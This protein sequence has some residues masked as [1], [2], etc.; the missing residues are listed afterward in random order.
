[1]Y[2]K[3]LLCMIIEIS[4]EQ[5]VYLIVRRGRWDDTEIDFQHTVRI[6]PQS[7]RRG[8]VSSLLDR[9]RQASD[10]PLQECLRQVCTLEEGRTM[11]V[12]PPSLLHPPGSI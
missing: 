9:K 12:K 7:N 1:M 5:E 11:S 6:Q 8:R 3:A 10:Q 4:C 2:L